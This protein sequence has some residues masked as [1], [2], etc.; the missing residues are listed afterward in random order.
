MTLL[1]LY[2]L[3]LSLLGYFDIPKKIYLP[4]IPEIQ[5]TLTQSQEGNLQIK[6]IVNK[7]RKTDKEGNGILRNT[8]NQ[9]AYHILS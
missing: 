3:E 7:K 5:A 1:I 2:I 9:G 8:N 6:Q 4:Q